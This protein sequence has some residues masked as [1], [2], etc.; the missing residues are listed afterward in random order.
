MNHASPVFVCFSVLYQCKDEHVTTAYWHALCYRNTST[1]IWISI[2]GALR[3]MRKIIG[4]KEEFYNRY[5][6]KG[7]LFKPVIEAFRSNGNRYNL[8]NSAVIEMFEFIKMVSTSQS[9][10]L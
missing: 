3:F 6:V 5:I 8:M 9:L 7:C 1:E 10:W 4:L 2:S